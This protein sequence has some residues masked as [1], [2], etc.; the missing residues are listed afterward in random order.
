MKHWLIFAFTLLS[1]TA[2]AQTFDDVIKALNAEE[3]SRSADLFLKLLNQKSVQDDTDEVAMLRYMYIKSVAGL[4]NQKVFTKE[5]ALSRVKS[6]ENKKLVLAGHPILKGKR[7][8]NCIQLASDKPN[9]LFTT[10]TNSAGTEIHAFEYVMLKPKIEAEDMEKLEG[11][12]GRLSG[13]LESIQV[14]GN[15]LP[16]FKL[17]LVDGDLEIF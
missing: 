2:N 11:K 3:W 1:Q 5:E 15:F 12:N 14:E 4:L 17:I 6:F 13:T 9:T 16:R 7:K 8:S 10:A